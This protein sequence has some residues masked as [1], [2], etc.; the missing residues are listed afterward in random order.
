MKN[1]VP[2]TEPKERRTAIWWQVGW[3]E[4]LL[5]ARTS[6]LRKRGWVKKVMDFCMLNLNDG[7]FK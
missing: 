1:G 3:E 7:R 2:H 6:L 5:E 4:R